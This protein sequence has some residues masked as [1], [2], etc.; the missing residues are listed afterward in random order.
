[1]HTGYKN[2]TH[3][4]PTDDKPP[5]GF[6]EFMIMRKKYITIFV[7]EKLEE[8]LELLLFNRVTKLLPCT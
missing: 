7:S 5:K 2:K 4:P 3:T 6:A 1:M 8:D